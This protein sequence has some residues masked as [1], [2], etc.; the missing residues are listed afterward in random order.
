MEYYGPEHYSSRPFPSLGA[1][2]GSLC[3]TARGIARDIHIY[4]FVF[5]FIYEVG[6]GGLNASKLNA[7]M[8]QLHFTVIRPRTP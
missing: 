7:S 1:T 6:D 2:Q 5:V 4:N 3:G 8:V